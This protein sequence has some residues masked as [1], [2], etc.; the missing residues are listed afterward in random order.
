MIEAA[1]GFFTYFAVMAE[2][3]FFPETLIG[4]R[5]EW[6]T[7]WIN[8]LKDSY[9]H[10]WSYDE[11]KILEYTCH[12]AF[13]ISVVVTQWA[14][15]IVAKTRRNSIVQQGNLFICRCRTWFNYSYKF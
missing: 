2:H 14:D 6:E 11:R 9:G 3:G 10:E 8:D 7:P 12:T 15:L 13:M 1:A 5:R 4:L